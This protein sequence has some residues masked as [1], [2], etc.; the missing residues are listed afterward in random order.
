M[1]VKIPDNLPA[2]STLE[3]ENIFIM[4]ETRAIHQDI[5][6][7]RIGILNIMSEKLTTETLLLRLLSNTPLQIEIDL[8]Y[9]G[10]HISKGTSYEHLKTFYK[11]FDQIAKCKYDGLIITGAPLSDLPF[12]KVDYWDEMKRIMDW[13]AHNATSTLFLCWGAHA[14]LHH[15]YGIERQRLPQ[16]MFGVFEHRV[17]NRYMP[18]VRGFDD[19]FYTP[20]SRHNDISKDDIKKVSELVIVAESDEA[21]VYL[22]ATKDGKRIFITGHSEYDPLTLK[23]E[24]ERDLNKGIP[25]NIPKNYFPN[26]DPSQMPVVRWRSN[27]NLLFTNWLNYYVYQQTPYNLN[28]ID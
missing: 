11:S 24:Y 1:P 18:L 6:P 25:I 4:P 20:H 28:D 7:L 10:S 12:E 19:V 21:G 9:P 22:L 3:Q 16:K 27:A 23:Y 26:D 8:L 5:R 17:V 13:S 2:I 14:G 15:F